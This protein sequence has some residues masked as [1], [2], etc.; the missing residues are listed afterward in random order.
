MKKASNVTV[1]APFVHFKKVPY[2][3]KRGLI[4]G[5]LKTK[6]KKQILTL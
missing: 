6:K 1:T 5:R 3:I 4:V 2:K